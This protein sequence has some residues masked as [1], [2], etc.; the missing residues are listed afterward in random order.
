MLQKEIHYKV[1]DT[2]VP[3]ANAGDS[4]ST[5]SSTKSAAT[6]MKHLKAVAASTLKT[7]KCKADGGQEPS[8]D[9]TS[10]KGS[11]RHQS[12][13]ASVI[14]VDDDDDDG[15]VPDVVVDPGKAA[16]E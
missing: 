16:E 12:W 15:E 13:K 10:D 3:K 4:T 11:S 14:D 2:M 6:S 5:K 9:D 1:I 8:D 7:I